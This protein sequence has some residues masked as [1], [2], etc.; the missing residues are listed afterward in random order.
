M[1]TAAI[2]PMCCCAEGNF[3]SGAMNRFEAVAQKPATTFQTIDWL[4]LDPPEPPPVSTVPIVAKNTFKVAMRRSSPHDRLGIEVAHKGQVLK[5][6]KVKDG[7]LRAW[8]QEHPGLEVRPEDLIIGVNGVNG[9]DSRYLLEALAQSRGNVELTM[10][11][12]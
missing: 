10:A 2:F 12:L 3:G 8:N 4:P 5:V 6:K 9:A 1:L 11:R 7:M